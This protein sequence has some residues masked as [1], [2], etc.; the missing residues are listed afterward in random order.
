MSFE[1]VQDRFW[2]DLGTILGSKMEPKSFPNR[3]QERSSRKCENVKNRWFFNVFGLPGGSK[4]D[5]K[6]TR[7]R[8]ENGFKLRCQNNT[9][10]WQKNCPTWLQ[11]RS[12]LEPCW[13]PKSFWTRPRAKK[14]DTENGTGIKLK[15]H[16]LQQPQRDHNAPRRRVK[17]AS[18]GGLGGYL[19]KAK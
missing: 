15:N 16:T 18:P 10:I 19:A 4:I 3:L 11:N 5:Q 9:Q 2:I 13:A 14:N 1:T 6:S 7:N 17:M 8:F 12:K